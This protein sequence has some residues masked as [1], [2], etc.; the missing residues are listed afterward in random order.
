MLGR[1]ECLP[2]GSDSF[3]TVVC[4]GV[5]MHVRD[6]RNA[7]AELVR[8]VKPGGRILLT[9]HNRLNP[10]S[11]PVTVYSKTR[12]AFGPRQAFRSPRF[13]TQL[14]RREGFDVRAIRLGFWFPGLLLPLSFAFLGTG[15]SSSRFGFEPLL[16]ASFPIR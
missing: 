9:F 15:L 4:I 5:L 14:L 11:I 8:V 1:I 10:L 3:D 13:F 2:F 16:E 6:D 7:L 12:K